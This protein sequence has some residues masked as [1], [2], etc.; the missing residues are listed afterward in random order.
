MLEYN[1]IT[2]KKLIVLDNE[3]YLVLSSSISK[4]SRQQASNQTKLKNLITGK[5]TSRAFHQRDS[6]NEA[7]TES[8][9]IKYLYS[10]KGA[11]WFCDH[12]N[13]SNRFSLSNEQVKDG[14]K[15]LK[16]NSLIEALIFNDNIISIKLPPKVDLKVIEAPPA[17]RGN[18]AQGGIKQ[19]TLETGATVNVPLFIDEGSII[20]VN[21]ETG[22]YSERVAKG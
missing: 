7:E 2:T 19:V 20:R 1:E 13:P 17:I 4:K 5:V 3:P 22:E 15:F 10:N 6:V 14:G 21:T 9:E 16:E 8:R 18:T 12:D 11:W